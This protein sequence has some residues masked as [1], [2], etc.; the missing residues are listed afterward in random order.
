MK[1]AV[2][3]AVAAST[4][5]VIRAS[6]SEGTAGWICHTCGRHKE[7]RTFFLGEVKV[8][9]TESIVDRD[10]SGKAYDELIGESHE[11]DWHKAGFTTH[12][13]GDG[14]PG[15]ADWRI[16]EHALELINEHRDSLSMDQRK[17]IYRRIIFGSTRWEDVDL[18]FR[19][20]LKGVKAP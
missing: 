10:G 20:E 6:M 2:A 1:W 9:T 8:W 19:A 15:D 3:I 7:V 5:W 17:Q 12:H 4:I 13:G 11:H 14:A 16:P 18:K